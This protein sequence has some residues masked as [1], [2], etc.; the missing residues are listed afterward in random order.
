MK[1][2]TMDDFDFF[3]KRTILRVD[4]NYEQENS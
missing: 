4:L 2:L 1:K 3:G